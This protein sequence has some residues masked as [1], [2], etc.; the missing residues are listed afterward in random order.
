MSGD[1]LGQLDLF[2]ADGA[3]LNAVSIVPAVQ[4]TVARS[5]AITPP[6]PVVAVEPLVTPA[7]QRGAIEDAG[8]ELVANRRNKI[9]SAQGWADIAPLNDALR[10]KTTVK[11]N[12][13]PKP[14]YAELIADGMRPLVAHIVKQVYDSVA[15]KPVPGAGGLLD[16]VRLQQYVRALNEVERG[17]MDWASD[18]KSIA[19]WVQKNIR[20]AGA[21]LGKEVVNLS[22]LAGESQTLI[23]KVFPNGWK[24]MRTEVI[25][26]GGNK[27]LG[28]LQPGFT[29]IK[30]AMKA[31]DVGW[32]EKRESW[33]VQGYRIVENPLVDVHESRFI[34]DMESSRYFVSVEKDQWPLRSFGTLEE[35]AEI[36]FRLGC[37]EVQGFYF[38]R[39]MLE[40]DLMAWLQ[41]E[42]RSIG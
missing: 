26:A 33:E 8:A 17:V 42:S 6:V 30:R 35:Q 2:G 10:V 4:A 18:Q 32:P 24:V 40:A 38:A 16:D 11:G 12:I 1:R 3:V 23:D 15:S 41:E 19:Q 34:R 20:T 31:L 7:V 25:T 21:M 5:A 28:A 13:W 22:D 29:D 27:L 37:D 14:D 36:L 9:R 39:P